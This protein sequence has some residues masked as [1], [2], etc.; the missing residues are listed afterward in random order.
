MTAILERAAKTGRDQLLVSA[1]A[2]TRDDIRAWPDR[3]WEWAGLVADNA[4]FETS[5]GLDLEARDRW[6]A[7]AI[8][9]SP[10]MFRRVEGGGSLYWLGARDDTGAYLDGG[11]DYRLSIPLPSPGTCSG[12]SPSTTPKPAHRSRPTR[13]WPRCGPCLSCATCPPRAPP[14]SASVPPPPPT[15][16][17]LAPDHPWSR[18]VCLRPHLR[19]RKAR[20]RR[21]LEAR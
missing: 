1:F 19:T 11:R 20:V 14:S 2:G 3:R 16:A 12:R 10:A 13:T 9:A 21:L 5:A 7:Q 8:V 4:D 17:A 15:A 18:V 6:F